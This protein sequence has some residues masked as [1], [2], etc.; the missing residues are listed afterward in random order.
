M[1]ASITLEFDAQG[2]SGYTDEFVAALWHASQAQ[3]KPFGDK[4]ACETVEK[5]GRE[6]IRRFLANTS[7]ALW[8]FQGR[9]IDLARVIKAEASAQEPN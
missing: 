2:L 9:H 3:S 8:H 7:P 1:K 5:I 4:E 6:I